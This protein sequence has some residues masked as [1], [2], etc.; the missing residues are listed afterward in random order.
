MD[1]IATKKA[2]LEK[3][4]KDAA[5]K[6]ALRDKTKQKDSVSTSQG[7]TTEDINDLIEKAVSSSAFEERKKKEEDLD[8][9]ATK[10]QINTSLTVALDQ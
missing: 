1:V 2:R 5:N 8:S 7:G 3:L 10:K 9:P 6:K 4:K